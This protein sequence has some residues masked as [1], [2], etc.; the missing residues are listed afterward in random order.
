MAAVVQKYWQ[1]LVYLLSLAMGVGVTLAS[2][3]SH[4]E[5]IQQQAEAIKR[6]NERIDRLEGNDLDS[7]VLLGRIDERTANILDRLK[8]LEESKP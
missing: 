3:R 2:I 8:R 6:T 1:M 4:S 5:A 7:R